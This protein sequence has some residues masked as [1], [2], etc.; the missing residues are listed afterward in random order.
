MGDGDLKNDTLSGQQTI[1]L[2]GPA[3]DAGLLQVPAPVRVC[4]L[5]QSPPTPGPPG[6]ERSERGHGE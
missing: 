2:K 4:C 6:P 5:G 1:V 3:E